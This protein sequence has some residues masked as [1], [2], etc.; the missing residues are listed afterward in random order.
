MQI[1]GYDRFYSWKVAYTC[2]A[3]ISLYAGTP[4]AT[5]GVF[6]ISDDKRKTV[7]LNLYNEI[8]LDVEDSQFTLLNA[9]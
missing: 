3:T 2:R 5:S 7:A 6:G 4:C 1:V 8:E 9:K